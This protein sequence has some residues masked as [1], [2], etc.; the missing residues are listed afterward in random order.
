[1]LDTFWTNYKKVA[2]KQNIDYFQVVI[3]SK[4]ATASGKS[5]PKTT[6]SDPEGN[7]H[8]LSEFFG[9]GKSLYIDIW[10]TWCI[11]CCTEIPY[12]E[13]LVEHYKDNPRL[14]FIS[15][16]IDHN[17][18]AWHKKLAKDKPQWQQFITDK[19]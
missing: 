17:I 6:F 5:C 18:D 9:K 11:P 8:S 1:M 14:Q 4:A 7:P 15:I 10:A 3:D 13:K 2:D 19:E 12:V 16:S